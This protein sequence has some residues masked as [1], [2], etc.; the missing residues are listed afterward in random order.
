MSVVIQSIEQS[1]LQYKYSTYNF[2]SPLRYYG[3]VTSGKMST[4]LKATRSGHRSALTKLV[5]KFEDGKS[6]EEF[7]RDELATILDLILDKQKLLSELNSQIISELSEEEL[8][9]EITESDEY[10]LNLEM[11]IRKMRKFLQPAAQAATPSSSVPVTQ[12]S[13]NP[14][15]ET[16]DINSNQTSSF[17]SQQMYEPIQCS[18]S[19][20][21]K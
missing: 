6:N 20:L 10:C 2:L 21:H 4:K 5:K 1:S 17:N 7:D 14:L 11:K 16:F 18:S 19:Q 8:E 12:S 13:V 15:A 9:A 3:A